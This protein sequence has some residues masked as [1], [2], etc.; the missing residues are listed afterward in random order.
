MPA[1]LVNTLYWYCYE[2]PPPLQKSYLF[3]KFSKI[4]YFNV[5]PIIGLLRYLFHLNIGYY[6]FTFSSLNYFPFYSDKIGL[7]ILI[8]YLCLVC[9]W[10]VVILRYFAFGCMAGY[11]LKLRWPRGQGGPGPE[12]LLKR[13]F[14]FYVKSR[15]ILIEYKR[16]KTGTQ[17]H[18]VTWK[19][20]KITSARC[21][22]TTVTQNN[23]KD[24]Q[25]NF[26][27]M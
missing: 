26:K 1:S 24:A 16:C 14:T 25:N 18:T 20:Y 27:E 6:Q 9:Y 7:T 13:L 4:P 2:T 10:V 3:C 12:P 11:L 19:G 15:Q 17:W 22:T 23:S 21:R 8:Q 5:N